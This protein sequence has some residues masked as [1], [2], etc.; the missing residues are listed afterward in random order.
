[1]SGSVANSAYMRNQ[2]S[3]LT[4]AP[5]LDWHMNDTAMER[6]VKIGPAPKRQPPRASSQITFASQIRIALFVGRVPSQP[7]TAPAFRRGGNRA[8]GTYDHPMNPHPR[9]G[10]LTTACGHTV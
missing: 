6:A 2:L 1:M 5:S 4:R 9:T 10:T 8:R 3:P 7:I